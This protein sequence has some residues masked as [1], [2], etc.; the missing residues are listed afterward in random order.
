MVVQVDAL[1]VTADVHATHD[2]A[3]ATEGQPTSHPLLKFPSSLNLLA[4]Q[5]TAV[6]VSLS[7]HVSQVPSS[8]VGQPSSQPSVAS[9][10][11]LNLLVEQ[12]AMVV[13]VDALEVAA[14]EHVVHDVA[15]ATEG[16]PASHPLLT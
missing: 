2:V 4:S 6:H 12:A 3:P 16:Q 5:V 13:Q 7:E 14:E 15:P 11:V 9:L 1:E 10:L 8:T